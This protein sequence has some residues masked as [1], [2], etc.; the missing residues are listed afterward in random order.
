LEKSSFPE[1]FEFGD[2]I[3]TTQLTR[4]VSPPC[5]SSIILNKNSDMI[6]MVASF[7]KS[8]ASDNVDRKIEIFFNYKDA[9][10]WLNENK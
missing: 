6:E 8:I 10:A 7:Y 3:K 9:V 1:S 5:K 2:I 4:I